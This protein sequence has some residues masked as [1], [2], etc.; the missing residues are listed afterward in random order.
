MPPKRLSLASLRDR[1]AIM[2]ARFGAAR[3]PPPARGAH[4]EDDGTEEGGDDEDDVVGGDDD[5]DAAREEG[6]GAADEKGDGKVAKAASSARPSGGPAASR[7]DEVP[8]TAAAVAK[9]WTLWSEYVLAA[10]NAPERVTRVDIL[11][12]AIRSSYETAKL[13]H[14]GIYE[15]FATI[16][17]EGVTAMLTALATEEA[18]VT[19]HTSKVLAT[20]GKILTI[21]HRADTHSPESA[22]ALASALQEAEELEPAVARATA[23]LP[24]A[25]KQVRLGDARKAR[26]RALFSR[27]SPPQ[28]RFR[29]GAPVRSGNGLAGGGPPGR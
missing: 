13:R 27:S 4:A 1:L 19:S 8:H 7:G 17:M 18:D 16:A 14:G 20:Y 6:G 26:R 3:G 10:D 24:Q 12:A 11:T 5:G 2:E 23:A 15:K 28:K 22:T 25:L 21:L 29:D 9:K